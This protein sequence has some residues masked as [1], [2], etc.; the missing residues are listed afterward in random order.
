[1]DKMIPNKAKYNSRDQ[2]NYQKSRGINYLVKLLEMEP[3]ASNIMY[4]YLKI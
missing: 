4:N 3:F 1:M 2:K